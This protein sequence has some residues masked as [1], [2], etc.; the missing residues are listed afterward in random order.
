MEWNDTKE[1][2]NEIRIFFYSS[3]V[4]QDAIFHRAS[5]RLLTMYLC[6]SGLTTVTSRGP[7]LGETSYALAEI[8]EIKFEIVKSQAHLKSE[9]SSQQASFP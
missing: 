6:P 7:T 3:I 2:N 5:Y 4:L 1:R 8:T 9:I